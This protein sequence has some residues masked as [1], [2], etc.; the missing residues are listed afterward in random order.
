MRAL[1]LLRLLWQLPTTH[2]KAHSSSVIAKYT[3]Q[4]VLAM[5]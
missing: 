3:N 4:V 5:E 2:K 1:Q